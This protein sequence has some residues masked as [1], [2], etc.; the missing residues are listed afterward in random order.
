LLE[1]VPFSNEIELS[2]IHEI[3]SFRGRFCEQA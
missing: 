3:C 2:Q 1:L